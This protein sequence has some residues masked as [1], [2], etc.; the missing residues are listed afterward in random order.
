MKR[1]YLTLFMV[2]ALALCLGFSAYAA[3]I[4]VDADELTDIHAAINE[5]AVGDS[6]VVNLTND[7]II[8]NTSSAIKVEK[9]ITVTI[10]FNNHII[11]NNGGGGGAGAVYGMLVKSRNARLILNGSTPDIDYVEFEN[12]T[13]TKIT[14][15]GG[16][17]VNP[18][19]EAGV[20]YPDYASDGP[21]IVLYNGNIE[22]NNVY[23]RQYNTG[24]WGIF[25]Y[26]NCGS[27]VEVENNIKIDNSVVRSASSRYAA[28]GTRQGNSKLVKCLVEID[29][30]VIYGTGTTEWISMGA[31]SYIKNS[32]IKEQALKIDSYMED[33]FARTGEETVLQNV[34]F[35]TPLQSCTGTIYIKMIDCSFPNG[36]DIHV[37]GD[38][39]GQTV[40]TITETA[41]C[42]KGGRQSSITC[43]KGGG[44]TLKSFDAFPDID[45]EYAAS[46]PALGH[47][48]DLNE[49]Q[50]LVYENGFI[51]RGAYVCK[52]VRCGVDG[53]KEK[54]PSAAALISFVG[55]STSQAGDGICVGYS[56]DGEAISSYVAFGKE[57]KY[58]V[59]AYAPL[60]GEGDLEP[61]TNSL[62][63]IDYTISAQLNGKYSAFEFVLKGFSDETAN[64][65]LVFGAYVY[66]GYEVDYINAEI[67]K[68]GIKITQDDY[69]KT[70]TYN[71]IAN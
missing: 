33:G 58:G 59:V 4:T 5:A 43:Y 19:K 10:N 22:L 26:P 15:S 42:D 54:E 60:E 49:I 68:S 18:N 52:C 35:E 66:D 11:V 32:R 45:E 61:I 29:N 38:S 70:V 51:N 39:K 50:D 28:I 71:Q 20:M 64:S 53:V 36:M 48:A 34:I 47:D 3:E 9:D 1:L 69:A 44:K 30:S 6:V 56:V 67:S 27:G 46:N 23:L 2:M 63:G 57:F 40:F 17:I 31:N 41:T 13:D 65:A 16:Q 7:I 21:A 8:P 25:V 12:P 62:T 37:V 24:E 55:I 14:V